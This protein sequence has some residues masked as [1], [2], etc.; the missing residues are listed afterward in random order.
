MRNLDAHPG[1]RPAGDGSPN[2]DPQMV[3]NRVVVPVGHY[4]LQASSD[5]N[6]YA[7]IFDSYDLAELAAATPVE[8]V[9][10]SQR[11]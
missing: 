10:R 6:R 2:V 9:Y 11:G 3:G 7:E 4:A 5:G 1:N 8:P